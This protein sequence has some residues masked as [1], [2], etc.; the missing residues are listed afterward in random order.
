VLNAILLNATLKPFRIATTVSDAH[1][2]VHIQGLRA[3]EPSWFYLSDP[4]SR[5]RLEEFMLLAPERFFSLD[6]NGSP[7][8]T[9]ESSRFKAAAEA[10]RYVRTVRRYTVTSFRVTDTALLLGLDYT[11][12]VAR[13]DK[14]RYCGCIPIPGPC[15]DDEEAERIQTPEVV[16]ESPVVSKALSELSRIWQDRNSKKSVLISSPP[17]SGKENFCASLVYGNGRPAENF[18]TISL[19]SGDPA[20]IERQLLGFRDGDQI[21]TGLIA[22]ATNSGLFLDEVH[23]PE[24]QRAAGKF[25]SDVRGALLRPLEARVYLPKGST[26]EQTVRNVLFIMATS[27]ELRLL[28]DYDPQDFWTRMTHSVRIEHPLNIRRLTAE[29]K[30]SVDAKA[31]NE[32]LGKFFNFFWWSM[33]D[34]FFRSREDESADTGHTLKLLGWQRESLD[35]VVTKGSPNRGRGGLRNKDDFSPAEVFAT[36]LMSIV[37]NECTELDGVHDFS[38]RGIRNV[39]LRI[40]YIAVTRVSEGDSALP[41]EEE[42][43]KLV[44]DIALEIIPMAVIAE[45]ATTKS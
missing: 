6:K 34:E 38:I 37:R 31:V 7:V 12:E 28:R 23:Q 11:V 19:A 36:N 43:G 15:A 26:E 18:R 8:G 9:I 20:E 25:K 22:K 33:V 27:R 21:R 17:G 45:R 35:S 13:Y 2:T 29:G 44:S 4:S 5:Y 16:V 42:F 40:F 39:I 30:S 41:G 14:G 24:N 10:F 32:V 1:A 3:G